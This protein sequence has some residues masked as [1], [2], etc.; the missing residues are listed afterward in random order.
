MTQNGYISKQGF[1][2]HI[3]SQ[4]ARLVNRSLWLELIHEHNT[5]GLQ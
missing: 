1:P 3:T 2:H 5:G 4:H